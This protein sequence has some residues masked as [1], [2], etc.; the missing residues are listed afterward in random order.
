MA[1]R[2]GADEEGGEGYFASISDL[3]VGVLF[4]FLL[5]LTVFAL[6]FRDAED[7][8]T[9][10]RQELEKAQAEVMH[11]RKI[12]DAKEAENQE[13]RQLLVDAVAQLEKD[14]EL[15]QR[16]RSELLQSLEQKLDTLGV[17]V[18]VDTRSGILRLSGDLLFETGQ[19]AYRPEAGETVRLLAV[20][21]GEILPCYAEGA[22]GALCPEPTPILET[23]L[24]EGHTDRQPYRRLTI[25]E[26]QSRNDELST[27][28]ALAVFKTLRQSAPMIETLRT[29]DG[30]PLLGVS[31]YGERRPLADA[32]GDEPRHFER[33][34]R[35]DIRFVLSSRTTEELERLRAQIRAV[36][37]GRP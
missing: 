15:R 8:Q 37:E 18:A 34:R 32:L 35:I 26:S 9:V 29:S 28:R 6:N 5:M 20:V 7:D 16:L 14:I 17:Q 12:A 25:A 21:L 3:M 27:Q 11:Q 30:L 13:L 19:S 31:G 4:V 1:A 24:V 10:R 33:N 36:M 22:A 23:V 2:A